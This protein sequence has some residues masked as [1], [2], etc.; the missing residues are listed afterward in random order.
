MNI[1][2]KGSQVMAG[3]RFVYEEGSSKPIA[4]V[5]DECTWQHGSA[6]RI[7][8]METDNPAHSVMVHFHADLPIEVDVPEGMA[9]ADGLGGWVISDSHGAPKPDVADLAMAL[10]RMDTDGWRSL[11]D[12]EVRLLV[13]NAFADFADGGGLFITATG[14]RALASMR[15]HGAAV[16]S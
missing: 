3:M 8:E 14:Q 2:I 11:K 6:G 16:A 4:S 10:N 5:R 7:A 1:T 15:A 12:D 9:V 13:G